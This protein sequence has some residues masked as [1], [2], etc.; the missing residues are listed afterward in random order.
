MTIDDIQ[1]RLEEIATELWAPD[2]E[3]R[4]LRDQIAATYRRTRRGLFAIDL[5]DAGGID[6]RNRLRA[7]L[8]ENGHRFC[9]LRAERKRL[10]S[11][12]RRLT[13]PESTIARPGRRAA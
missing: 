3:A 2:H 9:A 13:R 12:L 11:E 10:Q 6:E 8:D 1:Q 4:E 7:I 5:E